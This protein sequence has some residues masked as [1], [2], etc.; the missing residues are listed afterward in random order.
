MREKERVFSLAVI[1][2]IVVSPVIRVANLVLVRR[3]LDSFRPPLSPLVLSSRFG[4]AGT[5]LRWRFCDSGTFAVKSPVSRISYEGSIKK[6]K[7]RKKE[8]ERGWKENIALTRIRDRDSGMRTWRD[9]SVSDTRVANPRELYSQKKE[10]R[11]AVVILHRGH[12]ARR[13]NIALR[14]SRRILTRAITAPT[15]DGAKVIPGTRG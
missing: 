11:S 7:K 2:I 15:K 12:A 8:N 14:T 1:R 6:K 10:N 4:T 3:P 9:H 5:D 13:V